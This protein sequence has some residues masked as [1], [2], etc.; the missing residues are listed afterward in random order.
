[1]QPAHPLYPIGIVGTGRV[2]CALATT[3][4]G[5]GQLAIWGRDSGK[6]QEL[7]A[8]VN[9]QAC[10]SPDT[11]LDS[12]KTV[13]LAVADD[14]LEPL[15]VQFG[16]GE[17]L[18]NPPLV[19]HVSGRSG[20]A[21]L[22]PLRKRGAL[23]AAIHPAMTFTGDP[24]AERERMIGARFAVTAPDPAAREAA[25][26]LVALL[27]GAAVD[28]AEE[29][30]ALYHAALSHAANHLVTLLSGAQDML[31]ASGISEPS[32]LLAPLIRAALENTLAKGFEALS[33]PLLRGDSG[34]IEG[35]LKAIAENSPRQLPAYRA[36]ASATLDELER[37]GREPDAALR[38]R[39]T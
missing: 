20:A 36:M 30:R 16:C 31:R 2:A 34:T 26:A 3:L 39:L 10:V 24:Q 38:A 4:A 1:M 15:I 21:L 29:H 6:A 25:H 18:S 12:C 32:P 35:H 14:A 7:A 17:A 22:E 9:G 28:V 8:Q 5:A 23:T 37:Q 19:C 11:M 33:G 27:G 13:I